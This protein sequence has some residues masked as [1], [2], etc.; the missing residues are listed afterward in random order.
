MPGSR[1][2]AAAPGEDHHEG[3]RRRP[4]GART[5]A[6]LLGAAFLAA[7]GT[8]RGDADPAS[9]VLLTQSV[10]LPYVGVSGNAG[11]RLNRTL[12]RAKAAGFP[13][14]AA[15]IADRYDL[16]G[17]PNLFG[18]PAGYAKFLGRELGF[19]EQVPLVVVM[20][21]GFGAFGVDPRAAKALEGLT[22]PGAA[23][24]ELAAGA[25]DAIARMARAAGHPFAVPA[26]VG[27]GSGKRKRGGSSSGLLA[28]APA[29]VVLLVGAGVAGYR[30]L[31][32]GRPA[33]EGPEA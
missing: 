17:V 25:V 28:L 21:N 33:S 32:G 29:I 30:R 3:Q 24:D 16:G 10:S 27:G 12:A 7:P 22:A 6:V 11:D 19:N 9:D 14:K 5:L 13:I 26:A 1:R 20:P 15:L 31:R 8:A 23:G 4:A 18:D 2:I